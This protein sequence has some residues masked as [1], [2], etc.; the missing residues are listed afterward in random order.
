MIRTWKT[1]Q[2]STSTCYI[3]PSSPN[4]EAL[5][6]LP[7]QWRALGTHYGL[8]ENA[9][10]LL[11]R[12]DL[13]YTQCRFRDALDITKSI[14]EDDRYNFAVYPV[15]LA[16][17]FELRKTN[18]LFLIAHDLADNHPEQPVTRLAVAVHYFA[19]ERIPEARRYFSK[20]SMMDAH[21]GA[22]WI[23]FAHT[24][25]AEGEHDQ[26]VSA[27]ST[28]ARLFMG[29]H[30]PQVFSWHAEPRYEQHDGSGRVP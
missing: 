10:L 1:S 30:L 20:A 16:C 14:L 23:G 27:Y 3:I 6:R 8:A 7:R 18:A 12:A 29:T 22:A 5:A 25:A 24:F 21:F 2:Q 15:H 9:D 4:T 19:A 13:L 11:A 17:L 28:A 26:A